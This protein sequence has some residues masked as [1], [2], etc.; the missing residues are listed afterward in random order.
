MMA[1]TG[2]PPKCAFVFVDD[3]AVIGCSENQHFKNSRE[4]FEKLRPYNLKLNPEKSHFFKKEV[5]Y[6]GHKITDKRILPD[7][8]KYDSSRKYPVSTNA[9][10]VRRFV[11]FY[12]YYRKFVPNC[13]RKA[14]PLNNLLRKKVTFE[15]TPECPA[16]FEYLKDA[17]INPKILQYPDFEKECILTT[18][19]STTACGAVLSQTHNGTELSITFANRTFT[20]R[21]CNKAIIKKELLAIHWAK[22]HFRPYLFGTRFRVKTDYRPL[23]CLF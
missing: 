2:L 7:D 15:W 21:E 9:D 4:V 19:A 16:A 14:Q 20:K 8:T 3:I 17:L 1:M 22:E 23:V 13:S 12:N 5:T 18:D 11:A 6:L 10:E